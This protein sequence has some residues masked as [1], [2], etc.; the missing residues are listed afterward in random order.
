MREFF[1]Q[2]LIAQLAAKDQK[3]VDKDFNDLGW[4]R[5]EPEPHAPAAPARGVQSSIINM[6]PAKADKQQKS[7]ATSSKTRIFGLVAS[8][9]GSQ[10]P[11]HTSTQ[12]NS[13]LTILGSKHK[14]VDVSD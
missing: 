3:T 11:T 4:Q 14:P 10:Q 5:R 13:V 12:A 7:F 8:L 6:R 2:E 1:Q 9:L